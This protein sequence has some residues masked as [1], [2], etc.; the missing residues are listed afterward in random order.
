MEQSQGK[1]IIWIVGS[2]II[3]WA[4]NEA[5]KTNRCQLGLNPDKFSVR[6][7]SQPGLNLQEFDTFIDLKRNGFSDPNFLVIHIGS[8]D[9]TT[10]DLT[11]KT[12]I[13][14]I[15]CKI[16][17]CQALFQ[18]VCIVWSSILPRRYW[19][20]AP[21]NSGA[22]IDSKRRRINSAINNYVTEVKGKAIRHDQ[23][24]MAKEISLYRPDGTHLSKTG[25]QILLNNLQGGLESF[26]KGKVIFPA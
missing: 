1:Q 3:H 14:D 7:F 20:Y 11:G 18:N 15:K 17:R 6:W 4:H 16:A 10:P 25:N 12:I 9:L 26:L 22:D 5:V 13:E 23:N 19:H 8:N 24:I 21:L 2:S